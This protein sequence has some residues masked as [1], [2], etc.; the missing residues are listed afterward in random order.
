MMALSQRPIVVAYK[1]ASVERIAPFNDTVVI[2][3]GLIGWLVWNNRPGLLG[4]LGVVLV[5][6]LSTKIQR[7]EFQRRSSRSGWILD[8]YALS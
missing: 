1:N 3:S 5:S 2:I 8:S 4:L 7:K 6:I